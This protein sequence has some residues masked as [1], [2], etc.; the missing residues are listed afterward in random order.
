M[1]RV[2]LHGEEGCQKQQ[3]RKTVKR[4]IFVPPVPYLPSPNK[5]MSPA[6]QIRTL[7]PRG[8]CCK[9]MNLT[10]FS[11]K[12]KDVQ[13]YASECRP[14]T[15][16]ANVCHPERQLH[17]VTSGMCRYE[18]QQGCGN[19]FKYEERKTN[20]DDFTAHRCIESSNAHNKYASIIN[21]L[22]CAQTTT[23]THRTPTIWPG[24]SPP[25]RRYTPTPPLQ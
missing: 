5:F 20:S 15:H 19:S 25:Q 18:K 22:I 11:N 7:D 8:S 3:V 2:S 4:N 14:F 12:W 23:T 16:N 9:C 21:R 6:R 24:Q 17:M 10:C 13:S 1:F